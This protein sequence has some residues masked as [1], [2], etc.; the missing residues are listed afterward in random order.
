MLQM[1][2]R[3][4]IEVGAVLNA[5]AERW[6]VWGEECAMVDDTHLDASSQGKS[7]VWHDAIAGAILLESR[8]TMECALLD[9]PDWDA[10]HD[11]VD[12]A[13]TNGIKLVLLAH[14]K[15]LGVA[16]TELHGSAVTLQGWWSGLDGAICFDGPERA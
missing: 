5:A 15:R 6:R 14:L 2:T 12:Q 7:S 13:K 1:T 10:V 9:E 8:S 11:L 3:P 16:H 4:D